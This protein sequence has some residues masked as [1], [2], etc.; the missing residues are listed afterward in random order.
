MV[1]CILDNN[2]SFLRKPG[3]SVNKTGVSSKE[4]IKCEMTVRYSTGN[5]MANSKLL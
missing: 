4:R 1:L 2:A 5:S 3:D